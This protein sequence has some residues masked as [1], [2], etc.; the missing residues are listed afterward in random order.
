MD[1]IK[2]HQ[3]AEKLDLLGYSKRS[4][5][6]YPMY[7][8]YFLRYLETNEGLSS[9]DELTP[10][11][12][13]AYH[14]HLRF[15]SKENGRVLSSRTVSMR[16]IVLKTFFRVMHAEKLLKIDY[17]AF[18]TPAT[19]PRT[20]PAYVPSEKEMACLLDAIRPDCPL[21]IRDRALFELLYA[22]GI[23]NEELRTLTLDRL[24]LAGR[25]LRVKG[26]GGK[27]RIVPI[28]EWVVP[29]LTEYLH[30]VRPKLTS[31]S[32]GNLAST[33]LTSTRLSAG[34][35]L[36]FVSKNGRALSK[37]SLA[38]L[39]RRYAAKAGLPESGMHP[40]ILR[41][42]CATHL[43][44]AGADIRY[45]QEL[46]GHASLNST[47]IYTKVEISFLQKAHRKYHPRERLCEKEAE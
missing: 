37:N 33:K 26:K 39:L 17:S 11:H 1:D 3:F 29:Y 46:L 38:Y 34:S 43:L 19:P 36:L 18:I 41:H 23:R 7:V 8:G 2:L 10:Q 47:Q 14:T 5:T 30:A 32:R 27:E 40:H 31:T 9:L 16:L 21:S 6:E 42:A 24:D 28:G 15:G 20:P 45:V 44:R 12:I 13:T 35:N 25:T 4:I 22:T